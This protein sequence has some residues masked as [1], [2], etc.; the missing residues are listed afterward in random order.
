LQAQLLQLQQEMERN[1]E[2]WRDEIRQ[3]FASLDIPSAPDLEPL[4]KT[5]ETLRERLDEPATLQRDEGMYERIETLETFLREQQGTIEQRLWLI[6]GQIENLGDLT[7]LL[8]NS[9]PK[10]DAALSSLQDQVRQLQDNLQLQLQELNTSI[11]EGFADQEKGEERALSSLAEEL[12][13][14]RWNL[15][16]SRDADPAN[17]SDQQQET[18]EKLLQ[19]QA[20]SNERHLLE[21]KG[22]VDLLTDLQEA[23]HENIET[24]RKLEESRDL[25]VQLLQ[26]HLNEIGRPSEMSGLRDK[27]DQLQGFLE[28]GALPHENTQELPESDETLAGLQAQ[29]LQL[30]QELENQRDSLHN[31][32]QEGFSALGDGEPPDFGPLM[33]QFSQLRQALENPVAPPPHQELLASVDNL[34]KAMQG[35]KQASEGAILGLQAKISELEKQLASVQNS[36]EKGFAGIPAPQAVDLG[37]VEASVHQVQ[38]SLEKRLETIENTLRMGE[39][40]EKQDAPEPEEDAKEKERNTARN[41]VTMLDPHFGGLLKREEDTR[42]LLG[43][44][45]GMTAVSAVSAIVVLVLFFLT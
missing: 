24:M 14:L 21:L 20:K 17:S 25:Q 26:E 3:L 41:I 11:E 8:E 44:L 28:N 12:K 7:T 36:M 38:G 37:P 6:Q 19:E 31:T 16:K 13:F 27:L 1:Q 23:W 15:D 42:R 10:E 18:A 43:I 5:L 40:K 4:Q 9:M 45:V 33:E 22:K 29:L 39:N 32:I 30:Q 2:E 34:E 35:Q